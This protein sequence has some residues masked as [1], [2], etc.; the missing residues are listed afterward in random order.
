VR[1]GAGDV[2]GDGQT[3]ILLGAGP[4]SSHLIALNTVSLQVLDDF[5]AFNSSFPF[6]IFVGGH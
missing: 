4:G 2:N 5:F 6:G 1:V 3:D